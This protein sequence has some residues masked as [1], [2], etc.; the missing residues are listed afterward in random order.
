MHTHG[1]W[2][3]YYLHMAMSMAG[4]SVMLDDRLEEPV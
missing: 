3:I 4:L 1:A 2:H